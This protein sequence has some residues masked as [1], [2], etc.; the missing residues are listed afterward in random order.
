VIGLLRARFNFPHDLA[1]AAAAE[2]ERAG[3]WRW[4]LVL[5]LPSLQ[6][7]LSLYA[8]RCCY[9]L[10]LLHFSRYFPPDTQIEFFEKTRDQLSAE[11]LQVGSK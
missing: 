2:S 7:Q 4:L 10:T 5:P 8:A 11:S 1:A 6:F 9:C 3:C